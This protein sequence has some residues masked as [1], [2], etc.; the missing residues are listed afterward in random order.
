MAPPFLLIQ[1]LPGE[2]PAEVAALRGRFPPETLVTL[3]VEFKADLLA[4]IRRWAACGN[5]QRL[6]VGAHGHAVEGQPFDGIG[7][8][9]DFLSWMELAQF[10]SSLPQ[11]PSSLHLGACG[12]VEVAQAWSAHGAAEVLP[13]MSL[14]TYDQNTI[15]AFIECA[16]GRSLDDSGW[17]PWVFLDEELPRL[18]AAA[19]PVVRMYYPHR[20]QLTRR[21]EFVNVEEFPQVVGVDFRKA[22]EAQGSRHLRALKYSRND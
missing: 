19:G 14:I 9:G 5:M 11:L 6:F 8:E 12:S 3:D 16:L 18:R 1:W 20:N 21:L 17:D 2:G 7:P 15:S 10:L 4:S 22:L 13:E